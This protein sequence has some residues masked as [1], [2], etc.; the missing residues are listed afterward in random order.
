MWRS[1]KCDCAPCPRSK[2]LNMTPKRSFALLIAL[3]TWPFALWGNSVSGEVTNEPQGDTSKM[4]S[5]AAG[6]MPPHAWEN[7]NG[8]QGFAYELVVRWLDYWAETRRLSFIHGRGLFGWPIEQDTGAFP[9]TRTPEREDS[10]RWFDSYR[11]KSIYCIGRSDEKSDLHDPGVVRNLPVGVLRGSPHVISLKR[12]G[13]AHVI[14]GADYKDLLR[15]LQGRVI[16]VIYASNQMLT[17]PSN[18]MA[19]EIAISVAG[20]LCKVWTCTLL[21]LFRSMPVKPTDGFM[22]INYSSKRNFGEAQD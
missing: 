3:S 1:N 18:S 12:N 14:E 4:L 21:R 7:E 10:F 5:W 20:M 11:Q 16:R 15:M 2:K 6:N 17:P 13:F 8:R 22:R 9:V 19:I